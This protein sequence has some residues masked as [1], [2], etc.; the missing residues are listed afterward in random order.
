MV[1]L[2]S[3]R[4][5]LEDGEEGEGAEVQLKARAVPDLCPVLVL[6]VHWS[7]VNL[8]TGTATWLG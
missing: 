1:T 4:W 6:K 3:R 2:S 8:I 7:K 5:L